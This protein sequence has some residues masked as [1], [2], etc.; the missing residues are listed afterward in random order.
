MF[1][2][3]LSAEGIG[4][5][6]DLHLLFELDARPKGGVQARRDDLHVKGFPRLTN[7]VDDIVVC[8]EGHIVLIDLNRNWEIC[9]KQK[10]D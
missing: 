2:A 10:K 9:A 3:S 6:H 1:I 5:G 8:A 7:D 4:R